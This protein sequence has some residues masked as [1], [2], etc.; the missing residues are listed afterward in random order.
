MAFRFFN[1]MGPR[2][3]LVEIRWESSGNKQGGSYKTDLEADENGEL[4]L[5]AYTSDFYYEPY[6]VNVYRADDDALE[7]L[8]SIIDRYGIAA[9]SKLPM[10]RENVQLDG[11]STSVAMVFE[12]EKN[13]SSKREYATVY[14]ESRLP[15]GALDALN[16]LTDC[17]EQWAVPERLLDAHYETRQGGEINGAL[18]DD[19]QVKDAFESLL[20]ERAFGSQVDSGVSF[21]YQ[22]E[23]VIGDNACHVF[24]LE[25]GEAWA[26]GTENGA[27]FRRASGESGW[28]SE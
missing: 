2:G 3:T 9:W 5:T 17:L 21:A 16:E 6:S 13:G 20:K 24:S 1:R 10:D 4:R 11:L 26:I 19:E 28:Q 14:Y 7:Q 18:P 15:V 23:E 8:S 12:K 22:G 25:N 27:V